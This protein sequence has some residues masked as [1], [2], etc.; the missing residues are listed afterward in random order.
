MVE[1]F[2]V[3][4]SHAVKK[5]MNTDYLVKPHSSVIIQYEKWL[6]KF[7]LYLIPSTRNSRFS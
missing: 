2:R 5:S 6:Q 4:R 3:M 7:V 1:E